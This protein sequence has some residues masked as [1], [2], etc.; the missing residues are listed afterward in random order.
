MSNFLVD[1]EFY[2][3]LKDEGVQTETVPTSE[4]VKVE[5]KQDAEIIQ[6]TLPPMGAPIDLFD[7]YLEEGRGLEELQGVVDKQRT[8]QDT[9]KDVDNFSSVDAAMSVDLGVS[10]ELYKQQHRIDTVRRMAMNVAENN[11]GG[12]IDS[13]YEVI[14]EFIYDIYAGIRDI[15]RGVTGGGTELTE[16]S[17]MWADAIRSLD[18]DEFQNFVSERFDTL[19]SRANMGPIEGDLAWVYLRELQALDAAGFVLHDQEFGYI[20]AVGGIIDL[21]TLGVGGVSKLSKA[22]RSLIGRLRGTV[23]TEAATEAVKGTSLVVRGGVDGDILDP[24][25][26]LPPVRPHIEGGEARPFTK[27]K[28]SFVRPDVEDAEIVEDIAP[29]AYQTSVKTTADFPPVSTAAVGKQYTENTFLQY[30]M[31]RASTLGFGASDVTDNASAWA[32]REARKIADASATRL[33]DVKIPVEEVGVKNYQMSFTL[34]KLGGGTFSSYDNALKMSSGIPG[35]SVINTRTGKA[36]RATDTSGQFAIQVTQGIPS[37]DLVAPLN[38]KGLH[39]GLSGVLPNYFGRAGRGSSSYMSNLADGADF[40]EGAYKKDIQSTIKRLRKSLK[41]GTEANINTILTALRDTPTKGNAR[42]WMT[43]DQF[44]NE[45]KIL[46][47]EYPDRKTVQAYEDIVALSDFS[48]FQMA[49]ERLRSLFNLKAMMFDHDGAKVMVFPEEKLVGE[50]KADSRVRKWVWDAGAKR[51]LALDSVP[52]GTPIMSF[53]S[54]QKDGSEWI[55]GFENKLT[56]PSMEDAFPYNAGGPRSN[57]EVRYFVGNTDGHWNTLLGARSERDAQIAVDQYNVVAHALNNMG[58]DLEAEKIVLSSTQRKTLDDLVRANNDWNPNLESIDEFIEF[59]KARGMKLTDD[60]QFKTR[61]TNVSEV[62]NTNDK[63]LVDL[64]LEKYV[65]LRRQDN[66]LVEFGGELTANPDPIYAITQ[67]FNRM[68]RE[69]SQTL[70]R[71][72]HPSA[73]VKAV[74]EAVKSK[75]IGLDGVDGPLTDP[76]KVQT[77]KITGSTET[78]RKLRKEQAII[79]RRLS[80]YEGGSSDWVETSFKPL[81]DAG[82]KAIDIAHNTHPKLGGIAAAVGRGIKQAPQMGLSLGFMQRMAEPSQLFLQ[83]THIIPI[84][85]ASPRHGMQ[86][87]TLASVIRQAA[88]S[89]DESGWKVFY[90]GIKEVAMLNDKEAKDLMDHLFDSGR[91]YM[92]GALV[93]D[94]SAGNMFK[95]TLGTVGDVARAPFYAGE[96]YA[97]TVSRITAY[98]DIRKQFPETPTDSKLFWQKVQQR[99]RDLSFA[100]NTAQKSR[101]QSGPI[102]NVVAQWTSYPLRTLETIVYGGETLTKLERVRMSAAA[103]ILWGVGAT[104]LYEL[105]PDLEPEDAGVVSKVIN[106]GIDVVFDEALGIKFGDRVAFNPIELIERGVGTFTDPTETIPAVGI[107]ADTAGAALGVMSN[108]FSGRY[109]ASSHDLERLVRTWKVVDSPVM[110]YTMMMEDVRRTRT[111]STLQGPFT[112]SQELFQALG[113]SPSE[114]VDLS[115][116][117]G[118]VFSQKGR[119]QKAIDKALPFFKMALAEAEAG[120]Y[121]SAGNLMLDADA[122]VMSYGL[123]D[124]YL[125]EVRRDIMKQA[126][127]DRVNYVLLELIK[128]GNTNAAL[129]FGETLND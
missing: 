42:T 9:L 82:A 107:V 116:A 24:V 117:S 28:K 114:V 45:Y 35:S 34:G 57:P 73:W 91:G 3:F 55:I 40:V 90:K 67:Q 23:G 87:I 95:G 119:K 129:R 56:V 101:I 64:S 70:Y 85:A 106:D 92:R 124:T 80:L 39:E 22:G 94:P 115:R 4:T 99:D 63:T 97:A 93:E 19:A 11:T 31:S 81:A 112:A 43:Q 121:E 13:F 118:I 86:G 68:V 71:M 17:T 98:L 2:T 33:I 128:Q 6:R 27:P 54:K 77:W 38:L 48:Y 89:T 5:Q 111:G 16:I 58:I 76:R 30:F 14:D 96:N 7:Q 122:I 50:L 127:F 62:V 113:I 61:D 104:G 109:A 44:V 83:S 84:T 21:A 46:T 29:S 108:V 120:N 78:A 15:P 66:A 52:D 79:S 74:Q 75:K 100:L 72:E 41:G 53:G 25:L 20:S 103:S 51:R 37:K 60:A 8:V 105:W 110:A 47:G 1:D 59:G 123:S 36:A 10:A 18:E 125:A 65:T 126:E 12:K 32:A 88:R 102:S 26:E 69:G 49:S